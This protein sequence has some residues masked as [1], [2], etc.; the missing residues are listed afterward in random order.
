MRSGHFLAEIWAPYPGRRSSIQPSH[1][2]VDS[3]IQEPA[4]AFKLSPYSS[5]KIFSSS[6]CSHESSE[7]TPHGLVA[8]VC[9]NWTELSISFSY[10]FFF[11]SFFS[12]AQNCL[13]GTID[14]TLKGTD[15]KSVAMSGGEEYDVD[16]KVLQYCSRTP[17]LFRGERNRRI[18]YHPLKEVIRLMNS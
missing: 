9:Y 15:A 2:F 13:H 17:G 1:L 10:F 4:S 16:V 6:Q 11:S 8:S 14:R 12:L 7:C 5:L 18:L 3:K